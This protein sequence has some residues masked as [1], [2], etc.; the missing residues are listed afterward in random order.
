MSLEA[1]ERL[2]FYHQLQLPRADSIPV[3]FPSVEPVLA[4]HPGIVESINDLV[5]K[6]ASTVFGY[7][8][9]FN[10][11][12]KA[13]SWLDFIVVIDDVRRFHEQNRQ[14]RPKDYDPIFGNPTFQTWL[15]RFSPNYYHT[16][17]L[18]DGE[19]KRVKYAV[20]GFEDFLSQAQAGLRGRKGFGHLYTAGRLQKVGLYPLIEE[21]DEGRRAQINQAINQARID[22][23]WLSLG[24]LPVV[25]NYKDL[26]RTY[27]DL[28]YAAD[29]R[30]EKQDKV[31][32]IIRQNEREYIV[33]MQ[34]LLAAF[35]GN[36][37]LEQFGPGIYVKKLTLPE[38][39]ARDWIREGAYYSAAINYLKNPLTC[40]VRNGFEYGVQKVERAIG[41]RNL[42]VSETRNSP[43]RT[44]LSF[45][46]EAVA[47]VVHEKVPWI[48]PNQVTFTSAVATLAATLLAER[49][50]RKGGDFKSS[51]IELIILG[52]ALAL[53][54][55]DGSL[56]REFNKLTPEKHNTT[57]G[58]MWDAVNDRW[59]AGVMGISRIVAA[60]RRGDRVGEFFA[61]LATLTN[62]LPAL[63]KAR[64]ESKFQV[65]PETS[66]PLRDPLGFFGVHLGRTIVGI[67]ATLY[68][69]HYIQNLAD[70]VTSLGNIVVTNR[71]RKPGNIM[72]VPLRS[73]FEEGEEGDDKYKEVVDK[74]QKVRD[75][76]QFR[77]KALTIAT[78]ATAGAVLATH[79]ILHRKK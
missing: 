33:M 31:D 29:I 28:S 68:P 46:P 35:V 12:G 65:Y 8:S 63:L 37:I 18:V 11:E 30:I 70:V 27:V 13:D 15:N 57:W 49:R 39:E 51:R 67:P 1:R 14:R 48:T 43:V 20:L 50:I 22:G 53:D 56:A 76:A 60:H 2:W 32:Q 21:T 64:G 44:A 73:E 6:E 34:D 7:G 58:G 79:F 40:G 69:D 54:F 17:L 42:G 9:S 23:V 74:R 61:S 72:R 10:G 16:D 71:R 47:R 38:R 41:R 5:G 62:P 26:L 36:G 59:G 45:I 78:V 52:I 3:Y 4:A 24:F 25:F 66:N 75:D 55:F 77:A 19:V